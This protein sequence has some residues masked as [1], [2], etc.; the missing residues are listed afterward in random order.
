MN[1]AR[2]SPPGTIE[3]VVIVGVGLI[4][5]SIAAALQKRM[6]I[7]RV[8]GVSRDPAKLQPALDFGLLSDVDRDVTDAADVADLIIFCTPVDRIVEGVR[9]AA[10]K[11]R[12]GTII[13]DVGS[14]K[15]E[16]C[17]QLSIGLPAD[18]TFVGSHPLAG[19]EKTGF[20]HADPDL[21]AGR[22]CVV[23]PT[24]DTPRAAVDSV[25]LFWHALGMSLIETSPEDHDWFLAAASHVPHVVAAAL[26]CTLDDRSR[27][28]A[29]SGFRDTTRIAASDP[30]LWTAIVRA[31]PD[32]VITGLD[33]FSSGLQELRD[34]IAAADWPRLQNLLQTAKTK[35]DALD[36]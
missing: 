36:E 24:A 28:F 9:R 6:L 3:T 2:S 16:I 1:T 5:G 18:V 15:G 22:A 12:P 25:S 13:T 35:R 17:R 23:T 7:P 19:S 21:F 32:A 26:A 14:V 31:N 20:E 4:G 27:H 10:A 34:A 30:E 11:C 33:Q 29:A 8:I